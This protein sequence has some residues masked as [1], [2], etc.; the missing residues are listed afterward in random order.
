MRT[1]AL[2]GS[3]EASREILMVNTAQVWVTIWLG[4][5]TLI[6]NILV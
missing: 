3:Q 6:A 4:I 1:N 2:A 5:N